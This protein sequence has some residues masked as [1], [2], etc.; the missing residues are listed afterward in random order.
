MSVA[1][2]WIRPRWPTRSRTCQPGQ[3]A[4]GAAEVGGAD[5]LGEVSGDIGQQR[6]ELEGGWMGSGHRACLLL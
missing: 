5:G 4:T 2:R 6:L 1:Q 3:A